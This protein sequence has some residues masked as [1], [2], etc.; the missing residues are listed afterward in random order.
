MLSPLLATKLHRPV[1][2]AQRVRRPHLFEHLSTGLAAGHRLTLVSAPAGF[3]K[4]TCVSEWVSGLDRPVAWLSLEP[5]DDDLARFFAYL[6]SALQQVDGSIGQ[7][8]QAALQT[9]S[10]PPVEALVTTL[11]NDLLSLSRPLL[12]V[13]DDFQTIR[14]LAIL[15]G[16]EKLLANQPAT[17]HLVLVTREDP[18]LPLARLRAHNQLTEVRTEELRFT[19]QEA[20]QFL[21][22]LLHLALAEEELQTIEDR[23]EGWVVGLQLAGLSLQGRA[24]PA[25]FI[26]GLGGS[27]RYILSYLTEQV[28][29]RQT[30]E[31]TDFLLQTSILARVSGELADA[32]MGRSGGAAL[33]EKLF[34]ANLFLVPLDDEQCWYR[35]HHL[36]ADLLAGR[37]RQTRPVAVVQELH[38]RACEWLAAHNDWDEAIRHALAGEQYERAGA[39][40]EQVARSMVYLGRVNLL[41]SWLEAIPKP[42]S[43]R[44]QLYR[45]WIDYMQGKM[46]LS[47]AGLLEQEARLRALPPSPE[48]DPLRIELMV[49]LSRYIAMAGNP[50]HAIQFA[51]EVL[52]Y[53]SA[54]DRGSRA[55]VVSALAIAHGAAGNVAE[56]MQAYDECLALAKASGY[57]ILAAHTMVLMAVWLGFYGQLREAARIYQSI[58][59]MG[60]EA[61]QKVFYPAGQGYVGLAGLYLEWNQQ[62]K[63]QEYL[64][65]GLELCLQGGVDGFFPGSITRARLRQAQGDL[66]G[67]LQEIRVLEHALPRSDTL[68]WTD[69]YVRILLAMGNVEG[70]ARLALPL[71]PVFLNE[72]IAA[73]LPMTILEIGEAILGHV[74]VAQGE[75]DQAMKLLDRLGARAEAGGRRGRLME[76]YLLRALAH[77]YKSGG[78]VGSKALAAFKHALELAEPEGYVVSFV[79]EGLP[80]AEL[81]RAVLDDATAPEHL[82]AYARRLL[83]AFPARAAVAGLA[84]QGMAEPLTP[85]ELEVLRFMA[86]GLTYE[87]VAEHLVVSVNTVR[88]HVKGI[89]GKLGVENRVTALERARALGL[90]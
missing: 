13:L 34:A 74:F 81:L 75:I 67:A 2:P 77:R 12:V 62:E 15:K 43:P 8:I 66:E 9:G 64:E 26:A 83:A 58:V 53:L 24:D 63:A 35:Y 3:G 56:T 78:T 51:Q 5:E 69:R 21:N 18:P 38:R 16:L 57:Y 17:L 42:L 41:S 73:Q 52:G 71:A 87:Q 19:R 72:A 79:E 88:F 59:D 80:V 4:T 28:L 40:V 46:D 1:P 31:V 68:T 85:R 30:D 45:L 54:E 23:T 76:V 82:Q 47:A 50:T 32:V 7:E 29:D 44:L 90:L 61:G 49:L 10:P 60:A 39:L 55:R 70:A 33:L 48:N 25:P 27:Q 36:F 86:A 11:L 6:V 14:D 22:G 65:Q 89:Y 37:L 84:A 20:D